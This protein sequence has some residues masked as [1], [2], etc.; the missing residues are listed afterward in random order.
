[1]K[2]C[3]KFVSIV[4]LVILSGSAF[5]QP[6][7]GSSAIWQLSAGS[8]LAPAAV[9]AQA[10]V[11][12]V[13]A[14]APAQPSLQAQPDVAD[15]AAEQAAALAASARLSGVAVFELDGGMM[16]TKPELMTYAAQTLGFPGDFGKNWDAM[17][18]YLGDMPDFHHNN[19]ILIVVNNSSAILKA[20]PELY[21]QLRKVF[22]L[23]CEN[24][25]E[26]SRSA[27]FLKFVFVP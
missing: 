5:A 21:S 1:M 4:S 9:T 6:D 22:G 8:Q 20:D 10:D 27:A 25:S 7:S 2:K 18:D 15:L 14:P 26:W 13:P 19:K 23:A 16:K 17:I 24:T 12:P 11:P 3:A